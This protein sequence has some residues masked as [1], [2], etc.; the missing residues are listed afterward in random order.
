MSRQTLSLKSA[1]RAV[2]LRKLQ[3][4]FRAEPA[5]RQFLWEMFRDAGIW[6][7][8]FV[9]GDPY[10]SAFKAGNQAQG[11]EVLHMMENV[12]PGLLAALHAEFD[13]PV[14]RPN[15]QRT[16]DEPQDDDDGDDREVPPSA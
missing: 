2:Y 16:E 7:P 3:E 13:N 9:P 14:T 11:L 10:S 1:Q 5:F 4:V 6:A 12:V 15:P 8:T